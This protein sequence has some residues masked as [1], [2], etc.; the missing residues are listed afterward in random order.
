[1]QEELQKKYLA[2]LPERV[3]ELKTSGRL[4]QQGNA[5]A[6]QTLRTLAHSLHGSGATFG[7]P[8]IS[9]SA[10]AAEHAATEQLPQ[11]IVD[12]VQ[13]IQQ[14]ITAA[15][16]Q[17]AGLIDILII[18]DDTALAASLQAGFT[19]KSPEYRISLASTGAIAQELIVKRKFAMILLD[20]VLPDRDGRDL[21]K[22]IK[23]EFALSSPVY[24]V[25][26]IDRE[27]IRMECLSLGAEKF[28]SKP[29]DI[30]ALVNTIDKLL[31]RAA[32]KRG[33][34]LVPLGDGQQKP[35]ADKLPG[36]MKAAA[37][38][39]SGKA[40]LVA[41]DDAMQA[42]LIKQRL[43]KEGLVVDVVDN[44]KLAVSNMHDK[45]YGLYILDVNM[46]G[47]NGFDVLQR[48]RKDAVAKDTPVI[49][50]TA[51][52]SE[53]DI[54]RAYELGTDDY[55]LKPFSVIQLVAR[56]KTLLKKST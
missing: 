13:V 36:A 2:S 10:R 53:A 14:I 32:D 12:L 46:P 23:H 22:E 30:D 21:L 41:E 17:A 40:V 44:G 56:A 15:P 54:V 24:V 25:S 51:M 33:L 55:I 35:D 3:E 6:E 7:F 9:D 49:M 20:L 27:L 42:N 37:M 4:L 39:L 19:A 29:I 5:V 50:L 11:K 48:L 26:G 1:M 28:I 43:Q 8:Q 31:K 18:D 45:P 34:S 38:S 52:G 47:L 16:G